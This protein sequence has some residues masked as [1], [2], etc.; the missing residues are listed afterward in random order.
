MK[1]FEWIVS[2]T[3]LFLKKALTLTRNVAV[4]VMKAIVQTTSSRAKPNL[5]MKS[6]QRCHQLTILQALAIQNQNLLWKIK[7]PWKWTRKYW[8][9]H[10]N[11]YR[12]N[13]SSSS[14]SGNLDPEPYFDQ[15][16]TSENEIKSS[17]YNTEIQR[18]LF[19]WY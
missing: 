8:I 4:K 16:K 2:K 7:E 10:W 14:R 12:Y 18:Q 17:A 6:V 1:R 9:W 11:P 13:I 3:R 19:R 5:N 15:S